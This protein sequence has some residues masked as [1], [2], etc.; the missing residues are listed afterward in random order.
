[1]EGNPMRTVLINLWPYVLMPIMLVLVVVGAFV[2]G[3]VICTSSGMSQVG[4]YLFGGLIVFCLLRPLLGAFRS[5]R[6]IWRFAR[7]VRSFET[8]K[9]DKVTLRYSPRVSDKNK[10]I[11]LLPEM[12]KSLH[13]LTERFGH[14]LGKQRFIT[15]Y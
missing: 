5:W 6:W 3:A 15:P 8:E 13:E 7:H 1:M 9:S 4:S 10:A 2:G 12:E 14:P 11:A